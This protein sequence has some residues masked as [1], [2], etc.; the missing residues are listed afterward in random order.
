M[1]EFK[2][3]FDPQIANLIKERLISEGINCE[4]SSDDMGGMYGNLTAMSG[5]RILVDPSD[6]S[7]AEDVLKTSEIS[8]EDLEALSMSREREDTQKEKEP[9]STNESEKELNLKYFCN[10]TVAG[11]VILPFIG[12]LAA[13]FYG[14]KAAA[15]F[16]SFDEKQ[17]RRFIGF[18]ALFVFSIVCFCLLVWSVRSAM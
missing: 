3:V 2:K 17:K 12:Q 14:L 4:V 6:F 13:L 7:K 11:L 15:E 9:K 1:I 10:W 5:V 8:D 16:K 18:S